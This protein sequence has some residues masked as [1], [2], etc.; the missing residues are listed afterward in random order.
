[1]VPIEGICE[2]IVLHVLSASG[3]GRLTVDGSPCKILQLFLFHIYVG[4]LTCMTSHRI[5]YQAS[6]INLGVRVLVPG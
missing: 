3:V 2:V 1:M 5:N 4:K 6:Y